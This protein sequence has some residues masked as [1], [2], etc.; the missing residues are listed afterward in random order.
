MIHRAGRI[1]Q[2]IGLLVMP[3]AIWVG[4]FER[5]ERG[6]ITLFVASL[7]VFY[8]GYFLARRPRTA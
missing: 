1:F 8:L 7:A 3:S 2:G 6:A 5:D 4:H